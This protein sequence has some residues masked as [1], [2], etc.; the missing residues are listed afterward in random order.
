M[1]AHIK[2]ETSKSYQTYDNAVKA[3]ETVLKEFQKPLEEM[4]IR[5][6]FVISINPETNRYFPVFVHA[7]QASIW[8]AQKGFPVCS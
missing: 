3:A 2:F 5:P 7:N 4:L 1:N 8:F 6:R